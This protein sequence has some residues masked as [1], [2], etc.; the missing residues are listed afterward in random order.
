MCTC[1]RA[2]LRVCACFRVCVRAYLCARVRTRV[3][4]RVIAR[5]RARAQDGRL[6][7]ALGAYEAAAE[8][9]YEVAQVPPP[10]RVSVCARPCVC[11]RARERAQ[12]SGEAAPL[13]GRAVTAARCIN[14]KL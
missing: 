3:R 11:V 9:G 13:R 1:V 14:I 4:D 8:L 12:T 6:L 10:V 7:D 2:C 5:A